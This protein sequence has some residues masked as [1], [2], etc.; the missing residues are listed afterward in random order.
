MAQIEQID[1]DSD[2]EDEHCEVEPEALAAVKDKH[3]GI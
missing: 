3:M 1:E 2:E